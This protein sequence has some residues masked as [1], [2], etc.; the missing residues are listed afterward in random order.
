MPSRRWRSAHGVAVVEQRG[1]EHRDEM[2]PDG[3]LSNHAGGTLGGIS[4][5]QDVIVSMALKPTSSIVMPGRTIDV[6][7]KPV[8]V[9]HHRPARPLRRHAGRADRRGHA[10]A[11]ADGS[12]PAAPGP[13]CRSRLVHA[14]HQPPALTPAGRRK[15]EA[16]PAAGDPKGLQRRQQPREGWAWMRLWAIVM[17]NMSK[18]REHAPDGGPTGDAWIR[19]AWETR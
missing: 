16:R 15:R 4:S 12:L 13:E 6:A 7:G 8:E 2:T 3:F 14:G 11:R 5:G 1:A 19:V 17:F 18:L 10:G 9:E